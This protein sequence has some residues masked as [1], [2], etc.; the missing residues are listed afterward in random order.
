MEGEREGGKKQWFRDN[1]ERRQGRR[2]R[3]RKG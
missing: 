3:G 2:R 1:V